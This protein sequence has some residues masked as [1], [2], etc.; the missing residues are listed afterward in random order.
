MPRPSTADSLDTNTPSTSTTNVPLIINNH[1]TIDDLG[2]SNSFDYRQSSRLSLPATTA[3][4]S[5]KKF[6][7]IHLLST[8][9][10]NDLNL[11]S[12]NSRPIME[13]KSIQCIEDNENSTE[14]QIT[15]SMN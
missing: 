8:Q 10:E 4:F 14:E 9:Q 3:T 5:N 7:N 2:N 6:S 11:S 1:S 13:D 15:K 12:T